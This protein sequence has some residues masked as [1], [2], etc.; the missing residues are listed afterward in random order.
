M[1]MENLEAKMLRYQ[2]LNRIMANAEEEKA[3]LKESMAMIMKEEGITEHR[4]RLNESQDVKVTLGTRNTK[5][6]DKE[7]LASDIGVS[8]E[9][10]GK[11]DTLV[12]A[13][14]EGRLTLQQYRQYE[15]EERK[16]SVSVRV[17]NA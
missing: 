7:E 17:V 1:S 2:E 12:K 6:L 4:V 5:K 14:E 3:L 8:V 9:S 11:K 15:Y 16:E 10:A 13:A